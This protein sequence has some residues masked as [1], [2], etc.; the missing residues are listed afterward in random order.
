MY[1]LRSLYRGSSA[2]ERNPRLFYVSTTTS[3]S[4]GTTLCYMANELSCNCGTDA[5][6]AH[7]C[8]ANAYAVN[9]PP[10]AYV[11]G[12]KKRRAL[13]DDSDLVQMNNF[14]TEGL[15]R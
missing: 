14:D 4:Q 10:C 6:G 8:A 15:H 1:T 2:T 13:P 3:T 12:R 5:A 7:E 11:T 9:C